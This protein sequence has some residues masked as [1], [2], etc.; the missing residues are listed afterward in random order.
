M[1]AKVD[2]AGEVGH[3][4]CGPLK[5]GVGW[6]VVKRCSCDGVRWGGL[7]WPCNAGY[8]EVSTLEH[9]TM[10]PHNHDPND[11]PWE[12]SQDER[13]LRQ[14]LVR[15]AGLWDA[16]NTHEAIF[17]AHRAMTFA[18]KIGDEHEYGVDTRPWLF[19]AD[20]Y[21]DQ[22]R[23]EQAVQTMRDCMVAYYDHL[24]FDWTCGNPGY[25]EARRR[26]I[27]LLSG[28]E[29][30]WSY[31]HA[32]AG[33]DWSDTEMHH[34]WLQGLYAAQAMDET[35][36]YTDLWSTVEELKKLRK[37]EEVETLLCRMRDAAEN[38][39]ALIQAPLDPRI[40]AE[41]ARLYVR[42]EDKKRA[43]LALRRHRSVMD[44]YVTPFQQHTDP[45][46]RSLGNWLYAL[47]GP[48]PR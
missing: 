15:A 44:Q 19:L 7:L 45:G 25:K 17:A 47:E 21:E 4:T 36:D 5:S 33:I 35:R 27:G 23:N 10:T 37:W 26:L 41:L 30:L 12:E 31:D 20:I 6:L 22:G 38:E 11:D 32:A 28:P 43:M 14:E 3:I 24:R 40:A 39:C 8:A 48:R 42:Q 9:M 2:C 34:R 46:T 29:A 1:C 13:L 18:A 16:G